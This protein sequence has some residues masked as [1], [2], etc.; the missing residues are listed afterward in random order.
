M[1]A[2]SAR[3]VIPI[4]HRSQRSNTAARLSLLKLEVRTLRDNWNKQAQ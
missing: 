1:R 2:R 3:N 4:S